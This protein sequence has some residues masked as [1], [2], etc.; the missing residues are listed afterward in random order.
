MPVR[1]RVRQ[2]RFFGEADSP[3]PKE[4]NVTMKDSYAE[5]GAHNQ[6]FIREVN[7]RIEKLADAAHPEFLCESAD[8]SYVEMIELSIA[9]TSRSEAR[10]SA[11]RSS[12]ATTTRS[13]AGRRRARALRHR[14]DVRG[15]GRKSGFASSSRAGQVT[16][17]FATHFDPLPRCLQLCAALRVTVHNRAWPNGCATKISIAFS[18]R[19]GLDGGLAGRGGLPTKGASVSMR[20]Q[21]G[22]Q[23]PE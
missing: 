15:S 19:T 14:R 3:E 16:R 21:G 17:S 6:A 18:S 2:R 8:T 10:P 9:S 20:D 11:S 7:E 23:E 5:K 22:A 13:R 1:R 12:P 4:G